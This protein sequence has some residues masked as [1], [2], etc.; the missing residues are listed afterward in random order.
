MPFPEYS[1]CTANDGSLIE[2]A[3]QVEHNQGSI[4]RATE[5]GPLHSYNLLT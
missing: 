3:A 5:V 4:F 1:L 2:S